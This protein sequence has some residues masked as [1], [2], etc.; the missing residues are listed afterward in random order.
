MPRGIARTNRI[1]R[2]EALQR[3]HIPFAGQLA[4]L[5]GVMEREFTARIGFEAD[6]P[7]LPGLARECGEQ[8]RY[9]ADIV[10]VEIGHE[11]RMVDTHRRSAAEG[12][13][14]ADEQDRPGSSRR[15]GGHKQQCRQGM[16]EAA[17]RQGRKSVH[18]RR[19]IPGKSRLKLRR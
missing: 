3:H 15:A 14:V 16:S 18:G 1:E 17:P 4:L 5:A 11:I 2:A 7:V 10:A 12:E 8:G 6:L 13:A 9:P 19:L